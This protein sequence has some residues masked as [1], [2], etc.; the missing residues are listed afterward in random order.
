M[1]RR[2]DKIASEKHTLNP[3]GRGGQEPTDQ[4]REPQEQD[5]KKR[6]GQFSGEGTA[7]FQPV[8]EP[9]TL[10]ALGLGARDQ[11][12]DATTARG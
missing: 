1:K 8:P 5:A 9:A 11:P 12:V 4:T 7:V 6:V 3:T 2:G 10:A